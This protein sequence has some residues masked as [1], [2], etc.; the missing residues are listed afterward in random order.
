MRKKK[1]T[2]PGK[3]GT[4]QKRISG[5]SNEAIDASL[6]RDI[7]D[8]LNTRQREFVKQYLVDLNAT[9][10]AIRAGYSRRTASEMG[11]ENLRKPQI[12]MAVERALEAFGG[13][14]RTRLLEELGALAFSDIRKVVHWDQETELVGGEFGDDVDDNP[15]VVKVIKSRV[16]VLPGAT[17]DPMVAAT[18]AEISQGEKGQLRV[19]MHEKVGALDK[20]ARVLG[21]YRDKTDVA[22]NTQQIVPVL[23]YTGAPDKILARK[24]SKASPPAAVGSDGD[25]SD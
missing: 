15:D 14:T 10:A 21:M 9:Q 5:R 24:A 11:Y 3:K 12:M 6:P 25:E 19:K 2:P 20:L 4:P 22:S 7:G 16:T 1:S 23:V 18:V 17:M 13:I 8:N